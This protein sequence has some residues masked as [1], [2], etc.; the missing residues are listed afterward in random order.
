[1]RTR[2]ASRIRLALVAVIATVCCQPAVKAQKPSTE[3]V[4]NVP[5]AFEVGSNHL[6]PGRY[7][8]QTE[9]NNV[10][11]VKGDSG[12]AGAITRSEFS[13]RPSA[14]SAIVF[15]HY[16]NR[17]FL[18]G[19]RT[20]GNEDYL[21]VNESKSERRAKLEEDAANPNSGPRDDSKVEV[22]LLSGRR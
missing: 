11:W 4:A 7:T 17:Y 8:V 1:M 20:E 15:H 2:I 21:W 5:F 16:G 10:L 14:N 6:A 9:G 13:S 3:V 18:R 12:S 19:V 22:A